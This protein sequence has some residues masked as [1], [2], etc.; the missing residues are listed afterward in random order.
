MV[1][2]GSCCARSAKGWSCPT[3]RS[4]APWSTEAGRPSFRG[5]SPITIPRDADNI[6]L[7]V[8]RKEVRL[9]NLRKV[10]W[11]DARPHE[12]RPAP[13]LRGRRARAPAA[14]PRPRDGD[15]ALPERRGRRV[16]LHEARADAAAGVDRD[17]LDRAR[18]GQR[19]RF[20]DDSG[21][22]V[23][24]VGGQPR[25]HRP[26][27]VV[28][29]LRRRRSA[30]L[31]ALRSRSRRGRH[32]RQVRETALR[33]ARGARRAGDAG[34]RQDHRLEGLPRLRADRARA[35]AEG[36]LDVRQ[37]AGAWSSPRATRS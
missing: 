25:L 7:T 23:A 28:R 19:H 30:R 5:M 3:F 15:E 20:P 33:P 37:G 13:V 2:A 16:L 14:S 9:T 29:P 17:L 1:E 36:G 10:F 32:V 24:A 21:P 22:G 8:D 4:P 12:G 11:P 31:P 6:A 18:L 35:D 26:E 27:P 34:A